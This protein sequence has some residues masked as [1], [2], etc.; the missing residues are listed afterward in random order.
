MVA[1]LCAQDLPSRDRALAQ[2]EHTAIVRYLSHG[3][4]PD[5]VRRPVAVS[6]LA[7][8]SNE[9]LGPAIA[10]AAGNSAA[11]TVAIVAVGLW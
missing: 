8:R 3:I 1:V 11:V 9:R 4:T 7:V 2:L 5:G 10:G 6:I